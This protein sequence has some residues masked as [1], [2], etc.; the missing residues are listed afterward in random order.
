MFQYLVTYLL[1]PHLIL[2]AINDQWFIS[3]LAFFF[4]FEMQLK[5]S[6]IASVHMPHKFKYCTLMS[7][8]IVKSVGAYP[9][10]F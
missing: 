5:T 4:S 1:F 2:Y 10:P 3:L 9:D 7:T 6:F 8:I